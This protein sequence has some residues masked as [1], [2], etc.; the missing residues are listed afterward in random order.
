ML[1]KKGQQQFIYS[2]NSKIPKEQKKSLSRKTDKTMAY[3][4]KRKKKHTTHDST[5]KTKAGVTGTQRKPENQ[6][7]F[8]AFSHFL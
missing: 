3:K 2:R 6:G 8:N 1:I 5:L 4:I 7:Q